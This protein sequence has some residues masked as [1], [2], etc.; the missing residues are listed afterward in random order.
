MRNQNQNQIQTFEFYNEK[1]QEIIDHFYSHDINKKEEANRISEDI[2]KA[3]MFLR[4]NLFQEEVIVFHSVDENKSLKW[5]RES[6]RIVYRHS[7]HD[8]DRVPLIETK[9]YTRIQMMPVLEELMKECIQ[10]LL[11]EK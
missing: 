8:H 10:H 1:I 2:K 4:E 9:L 3:E 7:G 5:D 11:G 6:G